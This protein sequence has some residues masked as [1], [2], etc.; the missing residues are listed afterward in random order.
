VAG[1]VTAAAVGYVFGRTLEVQIRYAG[2]VLQFAG[3]FQVAWG[4]HEM[5][6][7][8]GQPGIFSV[9]SIRLAAII[10]SF[11]PPHHPVVVGT[12]SITFGAP[13]VQGYGRALG[14]TINQRLQAIET[15]IDNLRRELHERARGWEDALAA[16]RMDLTK[17]TQDR[18]A[19]TEEINRKLEDVAVGGLHLEIVGLLWLLLATLATSLPG[20]IAAL[21]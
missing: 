5:R 17:E 20:E 11:R 6:R 21:F 14:G 19:A 4:V 15:E 10:G 18:I 1:L 7:E 2:T 8:Y 3:I 12:G 16:V 9:M 13:T